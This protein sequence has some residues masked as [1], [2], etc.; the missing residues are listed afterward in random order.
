MYRL[1]FQLVL[2]RIDVERAHVLA[3]RSLH[4]VRATPV[5]RAIVRRL[6]GSP[7]GCLETRALGL[8]FP[9]PIGVGAGVDKEADWFDDLGALG[10]GFVEVGTITALPQAGNPPPRVARLV[11]DRAILNRMGFPN[12]GAEIAGARLAARRPATIVGVNVGKSKPVSIEDAGA[13]YRTAVR[14]LAPV[15]DYLVLNVSSPNTPGLRELQD[16]HRLR[17]LILDVRDEL[18]VIDCSVPLLIKIDPDLE[19]ERITAIVTLAIELG[20]AGIVAVN[21]T[22][23]RGA[24]TGSSSL[25]AP[26]EG[27]GISGAPLRRRATD[28]LRSIRKTAGDRLVLISVGGV[29]NAE[30][31]WE[32][33]LAGATLVQVYTAFV[34]G[35]PAWPKRINRDLARKV[36]DAGVA[37]IQEL[38]GA[39][40]RAAD[41]LEHLNGGRDQTDAARR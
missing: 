22:V 21:T 10:F 37:S 17:Q 36:R 8:T 26:F 16:V 39:D 34:Y 7:D 9:S 31:V 13:D 23:A 1:F 27:G 20:L 29:E 4:I 28:V 14:Q 40:E 18:A 30:D 6:V 12:P 2:Q 15:S 11:E 41:G 24:L 33:I 3:K 5:G 25:T 38:V 35:G 32:R 19:D